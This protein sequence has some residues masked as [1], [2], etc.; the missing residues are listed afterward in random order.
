MTSPEEFIHRQSDKMSLQRKLTLA[1]ALTC[2]G[3]IL[4]TGLGLLGYQSYQ[5]RSQFRTEIRALTEVVGSY[6]IAPVSFG[7]APGIKEALSV[8]S[9]RP[10]IISAEVRDAEGALLDHIGLLINNPD[11]QS[12]QSAATYTG[13][14]LSVS[15][16]LRIRN[17]IAGS[18]H[19]TATFRP[20]L[21]D[22][23]LRFLPALA[24]ALF[25]S[26][27]GV[28]ILTHFL[29]KI[30]LANLNRL[31]DSAAQIAA[32]GDYSVRAPERGH[33]EVGTLTA[34]FNR[35]LDHL[36]A[37]D[38]AL[39]KSNRVLNNEITERKR[40]ENALVESS[41]LAG[42]AEV[43]TDVL[44]N[45]GNVLNSINVS[46]QL[47]REQLDG[48]RLHTLHRVADL[49]A[50][51]IATPEN[52][53]TGD[54]RAAKLPGIIVELSKRLRSER[55]EFGS[56]LATL[57]DNIE[58]V[59][60]VVSA[61]QSF[62]RTNGVIETL[63]PADV[64]EGAI[65]INLSSIERHRVTI[66]RQIEPDIELCTDRHSILQILVN[67]V[68]NAVN[69]VKPLD[70]SRRRITIRVVTADS[71]IRFEVED[72]GIGIA[73][74]NLT[75]VFQHGFTTREDGHGF[76]LHSGAVAAQRMKGSLV[77]HSDG[78]DTG[79]TFVLELPFAPP[80]SSP[81]ELNQESTTS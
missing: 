12:S 28:G 35:M 36:Q 67:L 55:T 76:G 2:L 41:R 61:Q 17:E 64:V 10:E 16:P 30:L 74:E 11:F 24:V 20:V 7:D 22:T 66:H 23:L 6:V 60:D 33:D 29:G 79:A 40:L 9:A 75:R 53:Y 51:H 50:P 27:I 63:R 45:V 26:L 69:A 46:A 18:L 39:R 73:P 70:L 14:K 38:Q 65:R 59:K 19:V 58:H 37:S 49:L 71:R 48:S 62:A 52:F 31:A 4:F 21:L 81:R 80:T 25:F 56:E 72:S 32:T 15:H 3:A 68:S 43:A 5:L 78:P 13:W 34:T 77:A 44:H 42:M 8:L 57:S 1:V 47:M 54:E